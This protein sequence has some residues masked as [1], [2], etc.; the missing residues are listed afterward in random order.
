MERDAGSHAGG[1]S[2][3]SSETP[4][5]TTTQQSVESA[6]YVHPS[7][8]CESTNVDTGTRIW[9]FAHILE[10]AVVGRDCNICDHVFIEGG[11][12]LG[13]RVT[14]KNQVMIWDGVTIEDD[15]FVGPSAIFTNDRHPRSGRM[16]EVGQRYA[17]SE[18]WLAPTTVC[19][20]ASIGAGAII[21]C[22]T[23]LGRYAMVAAGAIV[24]R[25][26]PDHRLVVGQPARPIGWVCICGMTLET[27]LRCPQCHRRYE[28]HNDLLRSVD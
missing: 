16:P 17:N 20:G 28:L 19:R 1:V 4:S 5:L 13:D 3:R 10:G 24:T 22:G 25:D 11:A 27:N 2:G 12:R 15:V 18:N 9:A 8:I 6:T 26:V 7:A 21:L 23:T 14:I